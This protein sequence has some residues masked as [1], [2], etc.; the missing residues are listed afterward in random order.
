MP[1]VL[2]MISQYA[3]CLLQ[4][5]SIPWRTLCPSMNYL[6]T[7]VCWENTYS[8]QNPEFVGSLLTF[9]ILTNHA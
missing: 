8:H 7:S 2:S 4:M 3:K 1:I 6:L 9:R 5:Q